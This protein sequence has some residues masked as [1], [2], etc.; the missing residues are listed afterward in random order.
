MV[1]KK[2]P[3]C[4]ETDMTRLLPPIH[5]SQLVQLQ[6]KRAHSD[7]ASIYQTKTTK[8]QLD[9]GVIFLISAITQY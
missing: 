9:S 1:L 2:V 7:E 8:L 3:S 6:Q 5:L 4:E